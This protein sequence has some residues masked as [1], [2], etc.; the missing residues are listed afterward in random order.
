MYERMLDKS[1]NPD[2]NELLDYC[3]DAGKLLEELYS[4]LTGEFGLETEIRF[5]YGNKYG[6]GFNFFKKKRHICDVFAEDGAFTVMLR[7]SNDLFQSVYDVLL[8]YSKNI[9]DHKYPCGKGGFIHYRVLNE[10]QLRDITR[11]ILLNIQ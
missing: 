11:L 2:F 8:D 7:L 1:R 3:G 9:I 6:W 4:T 5:P 10:A